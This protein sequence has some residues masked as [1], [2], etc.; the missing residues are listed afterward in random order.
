VVG[1]FGRT[2]SGKSTF[3]RLLTREYDPPTGAVF[4][5][6]PGSPPSTD[7]TAVDLGAWRKRL[8]VAP[9]RPFL[10]SDSIGENI[11]ISAQPDD[12]AKEGTEPIHAT[13]RDHAASLAALSPDLAALPEGIDTVVGERGIM[14]SG[15]QRQRAALARALYKQGDIIILDDVLSAV[16]HETEHRLVEALSSLGSTTARPTTFIASHR[17]SA[18]RHSDVVLVFDEGRLLDQGSHIDLIKRPGPYRD[19]WLAQRPDGPESSEVAS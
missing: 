10:F 4:I 13:R 2:G 7:L 14:L 15:G 5:G 3:I 16:D 18:L 8:A 11:E 19:T 6:A 12:M 9:Q 17:L 1:L